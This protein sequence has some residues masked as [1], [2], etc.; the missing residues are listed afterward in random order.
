MHELSIYNPPTNTGPALFEDE[1]INTEKFT[2]NMHGINS[3]LL[4]ES[5]NPPVVCAVPVYE[6]KELDLSISMD[7]DE[8]SSWN[9]GKLKNAS[10]SSSKNSYH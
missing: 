4:V 7:E 1:N 5:A 6:E 8:L 10:N 3:T 2:M 9:E